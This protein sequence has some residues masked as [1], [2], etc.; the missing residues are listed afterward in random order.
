MSIKEDRD[1]PLEYYLNQE[2]EFDKFENMN[3]DYKGNSV[4]LLNRIK[5][6]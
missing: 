4:L 2:K 6:W 1:Y 5:E 3:E